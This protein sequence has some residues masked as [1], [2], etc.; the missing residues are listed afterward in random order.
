MFAVKKNA[1]F[2]FTNGSIRKVPRCNVQ[3][4]RSEIEH[5]E[6]K[7]EDVI[8]DVQRKPSSNNLKTFKSWA[9]GLAPGMKS[10][11]K[12]NVGSCEDS[13]IEGKADAIDHDQSVSFEE[14]FGEDINED[15]MEEIGRR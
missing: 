1:V 6:Q 12:E 2:I 13:S 9:Q 4:L 7:E 8:N 15:E 5:E 14:D 10:S 11:H 3:L